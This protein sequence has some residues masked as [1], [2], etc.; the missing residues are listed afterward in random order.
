MPFWGLLNQNL[1]VLFDLVVVCVLGYLECKLSQRS[2]SNDSPS[3]ASVALSSSCCSCFIVQL[4]HSF[5]TLSCIL[6]SLV[7]HL[8]PCSFALLLSLPVS[9]SLSG[10]KS[11]WNSDQRESLCVHFRSS[12]NRPT[13]STLG[14]DR[15]LTS[16]SHV[17]RIRSRHVV[18]GL[19][20]L[21]HHICLFVIL[22]STSLHTCR[23]N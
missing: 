12:I 2:R 18:L 21:Y 16:P 10:W 13:L 17:L 4:P 6:I 15:R 8:L 22:R 5:D 1:L 9:P 23:S 11:V 20:F 19:L 7:A 3:R 14:T